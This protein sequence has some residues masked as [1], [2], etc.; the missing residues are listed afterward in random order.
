MI[1]ASGTDRTKCAPGPVSEGTAWCGGGESGFCERG[2]P[3]RV[4]FMA[5]LVGASKV[6]M[7]QPTRWG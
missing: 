5:T 4:A 3:R 7:T 2:G 1:Q 6:A